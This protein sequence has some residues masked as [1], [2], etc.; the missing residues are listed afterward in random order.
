MTRAPSLAVQAQ[1]REL[2][3]LVDGPWR[4]AWLWRDQL[5]EHAA[6]SVRMGYPDTHPAAAFRHYQ[7]S[8]EQVPH[9]I[10]PGVTGRAWRYH[11]PN[12]VEQPRTV[13]DQQHSTVDPP[14]GP[15]S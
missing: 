13:G 6:S 7:P 14:R 4:A 3:V 2:A 10:E 15:S 8:D 5:D 12:L 1:H 9:P 11:P